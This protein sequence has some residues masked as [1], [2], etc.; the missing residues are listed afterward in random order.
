MSAQ[1]TTRNCADKGSALPDT[2]VLARI[3]DSLDK[4]SRAERRVGEYLLQ[5]PHE[6]LEMSIGALARA[7]EVSEPTVA[8]YAQS[9]GFDGF[10]GFKIAF[11]KSLA[12][13]VPY[14]HADIK[15]TDQVRDVLPKVFDRAISTLLAARNHAD[16]AAFEAAVTLLARARRLEFYGIGNSGIVA[17]DAQQKFLRLGVP[18]VAYIDSHLQAQSASVL[19]DDT[20]VLAISRTGRTVDLFRPLSLAHQAGAKIIVMTAGNAPLARLADVHLVIDVEEDPNVFTPMSSRLAQLALIDA[21][22]VAVALLRGPSTF[23]LLERSKKAVNEQR[24]MISPDDLL[25]IRETLLATSKGAT[26]NKR[27]G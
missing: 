23:D 15:P 11:A 22:A 8:R 13:G 26:R 9:L 25:Q 20:V 6:A 5:R 10:R 14:L 12:T 18:V 16:V 27:R 1:S 7:C 21:L 3:R 4:M 19:A 24:T 17:Q 2:G